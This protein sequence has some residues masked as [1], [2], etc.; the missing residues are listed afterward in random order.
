MIEQIDII[1]TS[2][3][4]IGFTDH[5][6]VCLELQVRYL[7]RAI[8][9]ISTGDDGDPDQRFCWTCEANNAVVDWWKT[10][11]TERKELFVD[12]VRARRIEVCALPFNYHP[13][14]SA[15]Q[16]RTMANWMPA[17]L[18][19]AVK[20]RTIMQN[21]VTG[22]SRAGVM[23]LL[24]KGVD[25]LWMAL[26]CD[27]TGP[28]MAQPSA[29]WWAMPDGTRI[30]V[31]NSIKYADGYFLF[32]EVEWRRGPLPK[33][34][35]TRYRP[36]VKGDFFSTDPA[37]LRRA[38]DLCSAKVR[39]WIEQGYTHSR[40][41]V[42]MT[43]MWRVDNDPP[44]HLLSDFVSAWNAE[45][46]TPRLALTTPSRALDAVKL[47]IADSIPT[48]QGEWT[49]WFANGIASMP[50]ELS[51]SRKAKR[52]ID[53]LDSSFYDPSLVDPGL[54]EDCIRRLC[55][56]DEHT[57]T[58]WDSVAAP[59]SLETKGAFAEKSA[60][61]YR[62]RA[63]AELLLADANRATS[64]RDKGIHLINPYPLPYAGWVRLTNDCLR[65]D[66][67]GV[68]D[69]A[70]GEQ[71]PFD[72]LPGLAA[73][74]TIPS[75]ASQFTP[76]NAARLFP[77]NIE[78]KCLRFWVKRLGPNE[79]RSFHLLTEISPSDAPAVVG[80]RIETD[81][82]GWPAS[83]HWD[84]AA[85]FVSPIGDLVSLEVGGLSPRYTYKDILQQ[86]TLDR[87]LEARD[88]HADFIQAIPDGPAT[89]RDTGPTIVYEQYLSHPRLHRLRRVLEV[90]KDAPR[91]KLCITI[92]RISKPDA[93]EI[94]YIRFPLDCSGSGMHVTNGGVPFR[95][96]GE[97]F[98]HTCRDF[99]AIDGQVTYTDGPGR[100]VLD[101]LDS[102][103][104]SFGGMNDGL[105]LEALDGDLATVYAI[106][107]N[108]IWY[109]NWLGNEAGVMEFNFDLHSLRPDEQGFAPDAFPV[110]NV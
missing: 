58:S 14:L 6:R 92:D 9:L 10:A 61:A 89:V 97:Q 48:L 80:P 57:C 53:A 39:K 4:D 75:A 33:A 17:E 34:A 108:N 74:F 103:L 8:D 102:A 5:P 27:T 87:R 70:T 12:M 83:I 47:E 45:G 1:N 79:I 96:E 59:D 82:S 90:F 104:V 26:N 37:N 52:L 77:D 71:I 93:A 88:K 36:P 64:P 41:P 44:C 31:W 69:V 68:E 30:F 18:W 86:P 107:Y 49:D 66:F 63:M 23:A 7:D 76:M 67:A 11:P 2:H 105:G 81:E 60:M 94:F 24:T 55:F 50:R 19:E 72:A 20:P 51:A 78:G 21:D 85:L 101:C 43:N 99:F 100:T 54:V 35:D 62:P 38:H 42:S 46:L 95:P 65:G 22:F 3:Y 25:S 109:T 98:S 15:R 28:V 106:I 29:F 56:F 32:E 91:V 16:W 13:T 110:V 84:D 73:F 40:V